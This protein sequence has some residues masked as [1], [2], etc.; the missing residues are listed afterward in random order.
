[1]SVDFD[2]EE[3]HKLCQSHQAQ[4]EISS[5]SFSQFQQY[6]PLE[7]VRV[8]QYQQKILQRRF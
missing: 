5:P 6:P 1:M 4:E 3:N 2:H 8:Y 7:Y